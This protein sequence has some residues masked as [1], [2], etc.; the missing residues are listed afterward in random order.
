MAHVLLMA[1]SHLTLPA[2]VSVL[3]VFRCAVFIPV[4]IKVFLSLYIAFGC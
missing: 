3:H 2:M 1:M 4:T